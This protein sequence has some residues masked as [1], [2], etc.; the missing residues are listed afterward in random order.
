MPRAKKKIIR[1]VKPSTGVDLDVLVESLR[2]SLGTERVHLAS[3]SDQGEPRMFIT[4][5]VPDLNK[6]LDREGRGWPSGRIVEIFGGEATCKTGVGYALIAEAQKVGGVAILYPAEGN[7]DEWLAQQYGIDIDRLII[8]DDETVEGVFESFN[9][10]IRKSKG[11][12]VIG[13]I[14]S[15]AGLATRE[16]IKAAEEGAPFGRDRS[17]QVRALLLSQALRRMGA[18]IPRTNAILFCVN[19]VRENPDISYGEKVKAPGGRALKFYASVRLK[20]ET[21]QKVK[22]QRQGKTRVAG[23]KLKITAVKNRLARPWQEAMLQLD[24]DKGLLP[25]KTTRRK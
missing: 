9:R 7:Y 10:A 23:F 20:I 13:M 3:D 24:F 18:Y 1:R 25:L 21:I 2:G 19:Q 16:E 11:G 8:G 6:V 22:R 5:G 14:D 12:L 4:S 17:A 15:I